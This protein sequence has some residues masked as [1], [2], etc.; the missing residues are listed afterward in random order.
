MS[1]NLFGEEPPSAPSSQPPEDS[2]IMNAIPAPLNETALED[3]PLAARMRPIHLDDVIGQRHIL[4]QGKPLRRAIERDELRSA[5]FWG[6]PGCGKSTLASVIAR[7]TK[8]HFEEVHAVTGGVADVRKVVAEAEKRRANGERT[9]LFVDEI[10]RF[11]RT[12][13]DA[14]LPHVENGTVILIG[15]TT[16]NPFHAVSGPLLSRTRTFPFLPLHEEDIANVLNRA[17]EDTARGLGKRRLTITSDAATYLVNAANG[18]ARTALNALELAAQLVEDGTEITQ[19]IAEEGSGQRSIT[20]DKGGDIHFDTA[21]ALIKSIRGSDPDAAVYYLT[22]MLEAGEDPR[23]VARRLVILASEDIGC[24]DPMALPLAMAA[25]QATEAIGMPECALNLAHTAIY[26]SAAPKSNAC[27]VALNRAKNDVKYAPF[28]GI[29]KPLRDSHYRGAKALG[30]GVD[31]LYPHDF[32][33]SF[34]EQRYLPE[35]LPAT[36][37][38]YQPTENGIESKIKA[39]LER[40]W[41]IPDTPVSAPTAPETPPT[42]E[43]SPSS[44][45]GNKP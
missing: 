38:Y 25:F 29:P 35:G 11:N 3:M 23:F 24:A 37:P 32:P 10:H 22:R 4:G 1:Y 9:L 16:E 19:E 31:Y 43:P 6:P 30:H 42:P 18:D 45:T 26:L 33:G 13:Q 21:S 14:M 44:E 40:L 28:H 41:G 2:E 7:T 20:Y 27:T 34:V 12:Q 17:L 5:I 15:A 8:A 39:R 36:G